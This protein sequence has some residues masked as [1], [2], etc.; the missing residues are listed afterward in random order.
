VVIRKWTSSDNSNGK[1]TE[2]GI[3]GIFIGL[4]MYQKGYVIYCPGS[5][6]IVISDD[7]IFDEQFS[8]A[9]ALTWQKFCDGLAL[10][11]LASF[12]P[13][14]TTTLEQTG[15][16][17]TVHTPAEEGEQNT[18]GQQEHS[19]ERSD[20]IDLF[21]NTPDLVPQGDDDDSTAES[22]DNSTASDDNSLAAD[23]LDDYLSPIVPTPASDT[24]QPQLP[25][26]CRG[27]R[28]RKPYPRYAST[29]A[30][31][32]YWENLCEDKEL[33]EVCAVEAHATPMPSTQNALSWEPAPKTLREILKMPDGPVKAAW[34]QS[35]RKEFKTLVNN[36]TFI[37]DS[38]GKGETV[39]PI[40]ETCRVKILS[41]GTLDK[42]KTRIVV[43]GDLQFKTLLEDKWSPTVSFRALKMILAHASRTKA[44]VKQLDFVGAFLQARTRSRVFVSIPAVYGVLFPEYKEYSGR[45]ARLAKSMYGMTL[46]GKYWLLDLQDYLTELGFE[47]SCTIPSLFIKSDDKGNIIYVLNYVDDMLYYGNSE[48][49]IS[50]FE[51]SLQQRFNL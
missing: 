29:Y 14:P 28:V 44:H 48:K 49:S 35:V 22:N 23:D 27:S 32:V 45:P 16:I 26:L 8:L 25:A 15:T 12:I 21:D 20:L 31:T 46:S 39:T 51:Q 19:Q 41:N 30:S 34:L 17:S 7:V 5:R 43:R 38:P 1:Q 9:I 6:S 10:H 4:D 36:N 42:L 11:P 50:E 13:D 18:Q 47:T 40:M 37:L 24:P 3:R 33:Q 2:R